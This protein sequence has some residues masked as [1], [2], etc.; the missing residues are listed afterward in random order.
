MKREDLDQWK[1]SE[2]S[3]LLALVET[4]RRYY[5]DIFAQLPLAIAIVDGEWG[6]SAVNREFRRLFGLRSADLSRMRLPDLLP[7]PQF[8]AALADVLKTGAPRFSHP[9]QIAGDPSA[10]RLIANIQ[11]VPGWQAGAEDELLLTIGEEHVSVSSVPPASGEPE[12]PSLLERRRQ[13]DLIEEAKRGAIERLSGR[14][15]HVANNLLM[16]IGG[17]AEELMESLPPEDARRDDVAEIIKAS[18]RMG[19]LTHDLTTLTRPPAPTAAPFSLAAWASAAVSRWDLASTN[20]TTLQANTSRQMLDLIVSETLRHLRPK[21]DTT[22]L[23]MTPLGDDTVQITLHFPGLD[24]SEETCERLFEPFSGPKE[25]S[26]PPLGL[27]GVVRPWQSVGGTIAFEVEP[28]EAPRLVLTCPLAA[29]SA[30]VEK[31]A[32]ILVVEDEPGI[33][34]LIVKALDRQGYDVVHASTAE[35]A[36]TACEE[37]HDG[38]DLLITDLTMPGHTGRQLAEYVRT[39]WPDTRVLFISG[40]TDDAQLAAQ[41][42]AGKLPAHTRFL[43]KPFQVSQLVAE[44]RDLLAG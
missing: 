37:A 44:A 7:D 1:S 16:I 33:R 34:S 3:R 9:V 20:E 17:Y 41:I 28:G 11:R 5:Q 22:E 14:L 21:L 15:A 6:I 36:F 35:E 8:E 29:E 27:A 2:V 13:R 43:A 30:G 19:A 23:R 10:L 40:F 26:D 18:A 12:P 24:A 25:G 42:G 39:K 32:S 31:P 38:I 4:E